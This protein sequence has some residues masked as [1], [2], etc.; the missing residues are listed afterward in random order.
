MYVSTYCI[1]TFPSLSYFF[2]EFSTRK[3]AETAVAIGNG[4]R[5]DKAHVFAINFFSDF[6]KL[7]SAALPTPSAGVA[8][9]CVLLLVCQCVVLCKCVVIYSVHVF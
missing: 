8:L 1:Y 2:L 7:V 4:Y 5:L 6:D 9:G 3:E